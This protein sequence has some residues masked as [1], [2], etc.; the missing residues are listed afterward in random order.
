MKCW[1]IAIP[2]WRQAEGLPEGHRVYFENVPAAGVE[3]VFPLLTRSRGSGVRSDRAL[4]EHRGIGSE[5]GFIHDAPPCDQAANIRGFIVSDFAARHADFCATVG[6]CA[7]A[8]SSIASSRT[9][10]LDSAPGAFMDF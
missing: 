2:I 4:N 10:G 1:I 6:W 5:M 3:A 7:R 8:R 9:E